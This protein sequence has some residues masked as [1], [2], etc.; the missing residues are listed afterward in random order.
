LA[1]IHS[2]AE[3]DFVYNL[4]NYNQFWHDPTHAFDSFTGPWLGGYQPADSPEPNGDWTWVTGEPWTYTNWHPNWNG[5]PLPEDSDGNADY[6]HFIHE[7]S[8][9]TNT[10]P[11]WDDIVNFEPL[12][13]TN[14]IYGIAAYVVEYVPS[15]SIRDGL[16]AHYK[17]DDTSGP[18]IDSADSHHGTAENGVIRGVP[19]RIG[20]AFQFD[21][22]DDY[23]DTSFGK[24]VSY[25]NGISIQAWVKSAETGNSALV[26]SRGEGSGASSKFL[27]VN[28]GHI[29]PGTPDEVRGVPGM[30]L[31]MGNPAEYYTVTANT[32]INDNEWHHVLGSY[33]GSSLLSIYVDGVQVSRSVTVS[34]TAE[35]FDVFK[36]GWDDFLASEEGRWFTG[37]ID[38]VRIWNRA[39]SPVEVDYLSKVP[40]PS[41]FLLFAT[42]GLLIASRRRNRG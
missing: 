42:C 14:G 12:Q 18:V 34:Q 33:D 41:S 9:T 22:I 25:P 30:N 11:Y 17:L 32:T 8:S 23:V 39:L 20:N 13:G 26:T 15:A 28:A 29:N 31:G 2:Q 10:T 7:W 37:L 36:I 1:T 19:G 4:S 21:G 40:E 5:G 38:D 3:N 27:G 35:S 16:I 24:D 6:L